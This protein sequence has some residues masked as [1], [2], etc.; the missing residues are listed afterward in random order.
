MIL[1]KFGD[2]IWTAR[3]KGIVISELN[4]RWVIFKL[5]SVI[6]GWGISCKIALRLMSLGLTGNKSTLVQVMTWV[7]SATKPLSEPMLTQIPAAIW[8]LLAKMCWLFNIEQINTSSTK[9]K[10]NKSSFPEV[11]MEKIKKYCGTYIC[12]SHW[13]MFEPN[14]TWWRHQMEIFSVLLAICAGHQWTPHTKASD[15]KL[16]C[17]L[18]SAPE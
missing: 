6:D 2:H 1:G 5:I 16:W 18:W 8:H 14:H 17:F 10:T 7:P 13:K 15:A 9:I 11:S 12:L 4:I 3:H